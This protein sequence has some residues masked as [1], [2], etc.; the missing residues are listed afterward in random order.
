MKEYHKVG[1]R[2]YQKVN[3]R[4]GYNIYKLI[5]E[6]YIEEQQVL[7]ITKFFPSRKLE[8]INKLVVEATLRL[9]IEAPLFN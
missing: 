6:E 4:G 2:V 9:P 8:I 1:W 7:I 3:S 5:K